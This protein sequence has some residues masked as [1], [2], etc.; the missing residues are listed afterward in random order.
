MLDYN[1]NDNKSNNNNYIDILNQN[2]NLNLNKMQL[3]AINYIVTD[4]KDKY[5]NIVKSI[6]LYGSCARGDNRYLSDVD[7]LICID[8]EN[9]NIKNIYNEPKLMREMRLNSVP[10]F[11]CSDIDLH[12]CNSN[13]YN[14]EY[15]D[16]SLIKNVRREGIEIYGK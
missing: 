4:F 13:I 6:Y 8:N 5:K 9:S 3:D 11:L 1:N 7:I 15:N 10:D 16:D 12:F 14:N 2:K